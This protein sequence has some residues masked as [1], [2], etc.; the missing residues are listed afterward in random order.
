[1][2]FFKTIFSLRRELSLARTLKWPAAIVCKSRATQRALIAC[3]MPRATWLE[4][5]GELWRGDYRGGLL[6]GWKGQVSYGGV[7]TGAV[8]PVVGRDR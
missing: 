6:R 3:N 4:G 1:M 8:C 7:T 5:T 2:N